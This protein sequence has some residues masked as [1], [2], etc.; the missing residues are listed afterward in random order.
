VRALLIRPRESGGGGPPARAVEGA[1][2]STHRNRRRN[3]SACRHLFVCLFDHTENPQQTLTLRILPASNELQL[4]RPL[5]HA[6][7]VIGP[8]TS[9]RTRWRGP[10]APFHSAGADKHCR[11]RDACAPEL[12]LILLRSAKKPRGGGAPTGA[13]F[14][15]PRLRSA[16]ARPA[17]RARL[18]ALHRGSRLGDRTPPL[19]LGPRFLESPDANGLL[20]LSGASAASSSQPGRSAG[21]AGSRSRP[22]AGCESRP[23]APHSLRISGS[24]RESAP[25]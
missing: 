5:H 2:A 4:R 20:A 8:A 15:C 14:H 12:C 19:S 10:P 17:G 16:E 24:P 25:R 18:S 6:E 23:Q 7:P 22:G 1:S 13:T 9:G 11:S 3:P 21:R